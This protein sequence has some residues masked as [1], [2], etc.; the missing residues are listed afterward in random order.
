MAPSKENHVGDETFDY[1]D[2]YGVTRKRS[3]VLP[4]IIVAIIGVPWTIW[5]ALD[6]S[7]PE[8]RSMLYSFSITGER[9]ITMRYGIERRDPEAVVI[10]TLLTLDIDK[11]VVGQ[12][13]DQID[14][15]EKKVIRTVAI[16]AR[17]TPVSARIA[18]CRIS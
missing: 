2:R 16:P 10:C 8:L 4:A 14:G 3:W 6:H 1:N 17:L 5:A 18:A 11:N 9:E 7:Q 15:G 13:D 12:I